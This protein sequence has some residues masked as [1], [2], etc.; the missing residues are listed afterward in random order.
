M[1]VVIPAW[2][3][4]AGFKYAALSAVT[5]AGCPVY[6]IGNANLG[7]GKFIPIMDFGHANEVKGRLIPHLGNS[8]P[9]QA[10]AIA[11]WFV[12]RDLIEVHGI[13]PPLFIADWDTLT[14][15]NMNEAHLPFRCCDF[16]VSVDKPGVHTAPLF[17]NRVEPVI[18]FCDLVN[19]MLNCRSPFLAEANDMNLWT[20]STYAH[21][22]AF[23]D[24]SKVVKKTTFDHHL[25]HDGRGR[26]SMDRG[27]KRMGWKNGFPY[28]KTFYFG[29]G[30]RA[31]TL[32]CWGV[33]KGKEQG[34]WEASIR[35]LK[36][37]ESFDH[38]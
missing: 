24:T 12:V 2:G 32:H 26:W 7:V 17:I 10:A 6:V 21:Q 1:N 27:S 22:W 35:R 20:H 9:F 34:L 14:F 30:I 3:E 5:H 4:Y 25:M 8:A 37:Y 31:N 33:W 15:C 38:R 36:I 29:L 19:S 18:A 23:M 13:L 16:A 11:R 28:F